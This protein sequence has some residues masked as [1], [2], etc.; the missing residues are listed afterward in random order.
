[1]RFFSIIIL[2]GFC[3]TQVLHAQDTLLIKSKP[4]SFRDTT[5]L[6]KS[7]TI[8]TS[9]AK[10]DS[11]VKQRGPNPRRATIYSAIFPGLGQFYNKKYWKIPIVLAAVGIPTYTYF[12]NK[13]WYNKT[14]YALAVLANGSYNNKDSFSKVDPKLVGF[15]FMDA[16]HTEL[17][18]YGISGLEKYRNYFRS[19]EDY[20]VLFFLL[21]YGLNI[22]DATV[23]A[24]L[25][26]FDVD[27]DL[28]IHFG[29]PSTPSANTYAVSLFV[30]F[31]KSKSRLFDNTY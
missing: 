9:L 21:F 10:K 6:T 19:N 23:D 2:V 25:K 24:H 12:D 16:A 4:G 30:D 7:D 8:N 29:I 26:L 28:S 11:I 5:I 27:R 3:F 18:P 13:N 1:M 20:S 17:N 14:R 31:H 22:V 15:I